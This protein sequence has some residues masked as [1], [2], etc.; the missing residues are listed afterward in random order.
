MHPPIGS[1][2]P[3]L[4]DL[5]GQTPPPSRLKVYAPNGDTKELTASLFIQENGN[6]DQLIELLLLHEDG[7]REVLNKKVVVKNLET[8]CVCYNPRT[9]PPYFGR[10]DFF[11][12][13]EKFWLRK[14]LHWPA[15]LE[16][17]DN[18]VEQGDAEG[19]NPDNRSH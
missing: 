16:L 9:C 15:I 1:R 6:Q 18:L 3:R 8:G 4:G 13:N 12:G 7:T 11:T 19:L 5:F 10:K 2:S 17:W 14:N